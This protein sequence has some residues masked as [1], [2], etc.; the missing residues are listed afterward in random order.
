MHEQHIAVTISIAMQVV[1]RKDVVILIDR[2]IIMNSVAEV[3]LG[4]L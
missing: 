2:M 4:T 1:A 3:L